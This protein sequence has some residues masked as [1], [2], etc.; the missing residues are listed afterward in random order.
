[1][2]RSFDIV[3]GVI[4]HRI[5]VDDKSAMVL[6]VGEM[7]S[8]KSLAAVSMASKIDATFKSHR[9]IVYTVEEFLEAVDNSKRGQC[10]IWD[11][12]GVG[13]PAR[14]WQST[15]NKIMS[16]ITQILRFKNIAVIFTTPN[17]R[18]VD[19]NVRESMNMLIRPKT[20]MKEENVNVCKL[21]NIYVND[22][23]EVKYG[24]FLYFDGTNASG[25]W[26]EPLYIPRPSEEMEAFYKKLSIDMKN[27]KI[28]ELRDSI[29]EGVVNPMEIQ[30]IKNKADACIKLV[31]HC[32]KTHTWDELAAVVGINKKTMQLWLKADAVE[33][34]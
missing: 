25:E 3:C 34:T 20:I 4:K 33:A 30:G 18:F 31:Q 6:I 8:G 12:V 29:N 17:I 5:N 19:V 2:S 15:Q 13:I 9:T 27:A 28:K 23:G 26:I 14:E 24:K 10:I 11:E 21:F 22:F 7:G 1:M 16:I 32:R